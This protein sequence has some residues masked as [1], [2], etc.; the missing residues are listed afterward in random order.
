MSIFSFKYLIRRFAAEIKISIDAILIICAWFLAFV[1]RFSDDYPFEQLLR[2]E[3]Y[4]QHAAFFSSGVAILPVLLICHGFLYFYFG[5]YRTAWR[6]FALSEAVKLGQ[7]L[8]F[9][10]L[11]IGFF[12]FLINRAEGLPRSALIMFFFISG[13]LMMTARMLLI[14][15]DN[16][17][18]H[19]SRE[20][21]GNGQRIALV[22]LKKH[23]HAAAHAL[24]N[25]GKSHL[26]II[27]FI[28][29]QPSADI[30][31]GTKR[32]RFLGVASRIEELIEN[33]QITELIFLPYGFGV[34]S[35]KQL[36]DICKRHRV[37]VRDW[38]EIAN[39]QQPVS[40][41][42]RQS[43]YEPNSTFIDP[44]WLA[45]KTV[46]VT[47]G[48]G[49]IGSE[50]CMQLAALN[51][52]K[53]IVLDHSESALFFCQQKLHELYPQLA[54]EW[55]LRD[56]RHLDHLQFV[57]EKHR[58]HLVFH[59]AAYKHVGLLELPDHAEI[60]NENNVLGTKNV[61]DISFDYGCERVV[62]I[63]TDK[64]V[65]PRSILG[66]TKQLAEIY[67]LQKMDQATAG[68][69]TRVAIVRFG[70]VIDSVG[71]VLPIFRQQLIQGKPLTVTHPEV[72]RFFMTIADACHLIL[73]AIRENSEKSVH[74]LDMGTPLRIS[75]I[76]RD[77]IK[78][79]R[80]ASVRSVRI[81]YIG[82]KEGEKLS[83]DVTSE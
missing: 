77:L 44:Q 73:F 12:A 64:A 26:Q 25:L 45:T 83:E 47:G 23:C 46:L 60:A 53:L 61:I 11:S 33:H 71:S 41:M 40:G 78:K 31:I 56:I 38:Y 63:S 76:A 18:L 21:H 65:H 48:G 57:W 30:G 6:T 20:M 51:P 16:I 62:L 36:T 67:G 27:G 13:L 17:V 54:T 3:F 70:N 8:L 28:D 74:V 4:R 58:P 14:Y 59:A 49:S 55:C 22:G 37:V 39:G 7:F 29:K 75:D 15:G 24:Q 66:K 81:R 72:E 9:L 43:N 52:E 19:R 32:L 1:L 80:L 10:T 34:A 69:T 79:H 42:L 5:I 35:K 2:Y 50:L 68:Q 82:L